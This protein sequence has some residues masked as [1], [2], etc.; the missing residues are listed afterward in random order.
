MIGDRGRGHR[1]GDAGERHRQR[2]AARD[3]ED[4][5]EAGH[6]SHYNDRVRRVLIFDA[7]NTLLR[8]NYRAI[9]EHLV[10]RGR[11]VTAADVED[12]ELRGRVRLDAHPETAGS[13]ESAGTRDRYVRYLLEPLGITDDAEVADIGR[14]RASFNAPWGLWT[15]AD[16]EA[17]AALRRVKAAGLGA[18]V[19]SNSNGRAGAILR[20]A[21]LGAE[22]DFVIDS[23][24][25]GVEKPDP[26]IFALA[27][28]AARAAAGEAVYV[29][30]LYSVDVLGARAAGLDAILIDPRGYGGPRDCPVARGIAEAV[31]IAL[32]LD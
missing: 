31:S 19:I 1:E 4:S 5:A 6:G 28:E 21:G 14:W 32:A 27:L 9:A 20:A 17:A 23:G 25:V 16:P 30:D 13:T 26:R 29:G 3:A 22:L 18:G 7:G 11:R 8:M 15:E 10:G 12:A 2:R 24:I